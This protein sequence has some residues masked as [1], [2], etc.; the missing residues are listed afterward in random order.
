MAKCIHPRLV[1][2]IV[3]VRYSLTRLGRRHELQG[4]RLNI[5]GC[6]LNRMPPLFHL[7]WGGSGGGGKAR[8]GDA[9]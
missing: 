2:R 3:V 7:F 4:Q 9:F 1:G 6:L 5:C 8:G